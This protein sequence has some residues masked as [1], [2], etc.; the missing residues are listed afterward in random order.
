MAE[1]FDVIVVGAGPAGSAAALVAARAGLKVLLLERGEYPG[2]KNV[3]GAVLYGSAILH[4]VIPNWWEQAPVER[5]INRR[6]LAFVSP[7]SSFALDFRTTRFAE[8]PYNGFT[9]LRPKFDRWFAAQAQGA[10]A[11]LL[12]SAVA[13]DLLH[14]D[15]RVAGVRVRRDDGDLRANVVIA[16]DGANSF[17]AKKAGLQREF[18]ADE[19]SLGVKEVIELDEATIQERFQL[20]GD[21]GV[22]IEYVGAVT[23][24]VHG[25]AFLYT[26]RDTLSVGVIGQISSLAE[27]RQRPDELLEVFKSH[28]SVAP[29]LRGG[30]VREYSAHMIPEAGWGMKP[31]L[32]TDGMLVAG[33]AAG[34][35]FAAGLYLEGINY[36]IQSGLAAGEAAVAAHR[37]HDFSTR[38][39][40]CY[41]RLLE[42]RHVTTDFRKF[43]HAPEFVN[44]AR[45]QNFYPSILAHGA[46]QLFR[47]DGKGKRKILPIALETLKHF[48]VS[49]FQLLRDLWDAGRALGW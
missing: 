13:D 44:S 5:S 15:G 18:R 10:G 14:E 24:D 30:R 45:L 26:N 4:E 17:L 47:V 21:E 27:R 48:R 42:A 33:D 12:C 40:A 28:P 46:E 36:A 49:P 37:E 1:H 3:S 41:E 7:E 20:G 31:K 11:F 19:M 22:A 38:G 2:S 29:L 39:L 6:V 16:C 32:Y 8:P 43:R 34:F 25:G 35:C 9:V 23:R